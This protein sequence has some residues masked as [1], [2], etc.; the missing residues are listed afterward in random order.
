MKRLAVFLLAATLAVTGTVSST[1]A[2]DGAAAPAKQ[3]E[4]AEL[5][6][7][8]LGLSQ[9]LPAAPT[10]QQI[11]SVLLANGIAPA[12][13]WSAEAEVTKADL[14][15]VVVQSMGQAGEVQN[16]DNPQSWV[17]YLK[18]LGIPIDT[19]G[20][21]VDALAP[22]DQPVAGNLSRAGTT[23]DPLDNVTQF[24]E[25]DE[26]EFGADAKAGGLP[27]PAGVAPAAQVVVPPPAPQAPSSP[28]VTLPEVRRI[29]ATVPTPD[30]EE[31]Q[32]PV[33]PN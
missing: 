28:T 11:F 21:A 26:R 10:A 29:V 16:Q 31:E 30:R 4:L 24:G 20:Q 9:Y 8:L 5:L 32:A 19:I 12:A 14:A 25:P 6:T 3:S 22:L 15:R 27:Q 18:G 13:G 23:W 7:N 1:M 33:T 17:N 2:Q